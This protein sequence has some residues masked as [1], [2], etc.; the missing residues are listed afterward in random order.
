MTY[1]PCSSL[2]SFVFLQ[3]CVISSSHAAYINSSQLTYGGA[4]V[5]PES[6]LD[7]SP[8]LL[9]WVEVN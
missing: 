8:L 2:D 9:D 3:I 4:V 5:F 6:R 7:Y 1:A